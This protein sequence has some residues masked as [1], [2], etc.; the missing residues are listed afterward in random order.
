[1]TASRG[2]APP[3]GAACRFLWLTLPGAL[4]AAELA[5]ASGL[6]CL[7]DLQH[8]YASHGEL[9]AMIA[10]IRQ[11][12]Q[13][14]FVRPP[15]GD[16][17]T[18][19]RAL[20]AGATAIVFPMVDTP[21]D[22]RALVAATRYPP[23]GRRSWG[24]AQAA[25]LLGLSPPDYLASANGL[26]RVYA[27]IESGRALANVEAIAA[28]PGLDGLFVGP[29]DLSISLLDGAA[30]DPRHAEVERALARVLAAARAHGIAAGLYCSDGVEAERREQEGFAFLS[31]GSDA[32]VLKAG[33]AALTGGHSR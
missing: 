2:A 30:A 6:P 24:P 29:Y 13:E 3:G 15:L 1:M 21:E 27:M 19:A 5:R 14:A 9:V 8:G 31:T 33:V 22:A 28:T 26:V 11:A 4:F 20:D 10:A 17:A 23:A 25:A 32:S 12:G 7:V 18:A 16:H